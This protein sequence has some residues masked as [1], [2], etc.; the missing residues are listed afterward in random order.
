MIFI[1]FTPLSSTWSDG[2]LERAKRVVFGTINGLL[3]TL[4]AV[5]SQRHI[6]LLSPKIAAPGL[7]VLCFVILGIG[8]LSSEGVSPPKRGAEEDMLARRLHRAAFN[9][10]LQELAKKSAPDASGDN[11]LADL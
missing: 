9:L 11:F 10:G 7:K 3:L 6:S 4:F 2:I 1:P 8:I 5:S